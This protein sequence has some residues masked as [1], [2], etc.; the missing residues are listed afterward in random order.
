MSHAVTSILYKSE[1]TKQKPRIE[2]NKCISLFLFSLKIR[3]FVLNE[4][5]KVGWPPS[6]DGYH[7][8]SNCNVLGNHPNILCDCFIEMTRLNLINLMNSSFL[9]VQSTIVL[10]ITSFRKYCLGIFNMVHGSKIA[11]VS[12]KLYGWLTRGPL[13][14]EVSS[15]ILILPN[16][17]RIFY[18]F[19]HSYVV[20]A[21]QH[22]MT[23]NYLNGEQIR[24]LMATKHDFCIFSCYKVSQPLLSLWTLTL[25]VTPKNAHKCSKKMMEIHVV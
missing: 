9:V 6:A 21:N 22:V 19:F 10:W 11:G 23:L 15:F 8:P 18:L 1:K 24:I 4:V 7:W 5:M 3:F 14:S 13:Q 12:G 16:T 2:L 17:C 25:N 20:S